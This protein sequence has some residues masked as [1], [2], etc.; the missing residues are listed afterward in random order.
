MNLRD[1]F[2][3]DN[4][5]LIKFKQRMHSDVILEMEKY[6]LL[7]GTYD[8]VVHKNEYIVNKNDKILTNVLEAIMIESLLHGQEATDKKNISLLGNST[9][10][11]LV[12]K[13]QAETKASGHNPTSP[14]SLQL[15]R[16]D[17]LEHKG[18]MHMGTALPLP[19]SGHFVQ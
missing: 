7:I 11:S 5:D 1:R 10:E 6:K 9:N 19:H 2:K 18:D 17:Q 16:K 4:S 13:L 8:Q 12:K 3:D 15:R 14:K